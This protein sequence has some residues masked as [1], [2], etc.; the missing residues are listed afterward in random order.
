M[1]I[2]MPKI[3]WGRVIK[4]VKHGAVSGKKWWD[5]LPPEKQAEY[6]EKIKDLFG[7]KDE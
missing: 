5:N 2:K 6:I 4:L 1:P 7:K 3:P